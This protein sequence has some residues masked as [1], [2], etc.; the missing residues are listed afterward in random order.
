MNFQYLDLT[1]AQNPSVFKG[2]IKR[3]GGKIRNLRNTSDSCELKKMWVI[4][5]INL[6]YRGY[7][8]ILE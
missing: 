8:V 3:E 2:F 4:E 1:Y 5:K 6:I 7:T